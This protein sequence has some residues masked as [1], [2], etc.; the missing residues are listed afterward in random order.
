MAA[1]DAKPVPVKDVAFRVTFTILDA[2]G[3]LVT[4]ATAPDS[5]FSEDAAAFAD[6]ASEFTEIATASGMYFLDIAAAEMGGDTVAIIC[7]TT[8]SG[9]KTTPI[10]LYPQSAANPI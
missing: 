3:D 9:A 6:A 8:T 7:K 1:G 5:E 10:V 2:D 4:G